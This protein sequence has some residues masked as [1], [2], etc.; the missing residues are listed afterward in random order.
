MPL[1]SIHSNQTGA[2]CLLHSQ[3]HRLSL[4]PLISVVSNCT[5][6]HHRVLSETEKDQAVGLPDCGDSSLTFS[7]ETIIEIPRHGNIF[8]L[9]RFCIMKH[10]RTVSLSSLCSLDTFLISLIALLAFLLPTRANPSAFCCAAASKPGLEAFLHLRSILQQRP[11]QIWSRARTLPFVLSPPLRPEV[12]GTCETHRQ[13]C[14][15][16]YQSDCQLYKQ[17]ARS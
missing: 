13:T 2:L 5:Q 17:Q 9:F 3:N 14:N 8:S 15:L 6:S 11:C 7:T 4:L 12:D 10:F 16:F 1:D